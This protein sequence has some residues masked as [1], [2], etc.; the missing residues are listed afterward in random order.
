[1][2]RAKKVKFDTLADWSLS[3]DKGIKYYS[4]IATYS[5]EFNVDKMFSKTKNRKR[6]YLD[7]GEVRNL[8][9]VKLNGENV[10]IVWTNNQLD[11]TESLKRKQ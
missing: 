1:M 5:K 4:G 10:G 8:A 2:G 11:I 9:K 6:M 7:L 3:S